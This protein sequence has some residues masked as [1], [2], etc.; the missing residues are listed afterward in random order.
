[1][2]GGFDLALALTV[3]FLTAVPCAILT[4]L[5]FTR[6]ARGRP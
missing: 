5:F 6:R 4:A 3:G 1:M 2:T